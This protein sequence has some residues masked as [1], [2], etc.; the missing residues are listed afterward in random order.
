[1]NSDIR[2]QMS[3]Y[4]NTKVKRLYRELGADGPLSLLFLWLYV[5]ENRPHGELRGMDIEDIA[6]A[7][8]WPG[9]AEKFVDCINKLKFLDKK[10]KLFVVHDWE[11][12][13]PWAFGAPERK[14]KAAKAAK[15]KWGGED[16]CKVNRTNRSERLTAAREKG[17]HTK[18]EWEEMVAFFDNT[19]VRCEGASQLIGVVKDHITPI[20]QGGSD[21]LDN[22][23][24]LCA[25][26]NSSKGPEAI[27]FRTNFAIKLGKRMPAKWVQTSAET[28]APSPSPSP[29]PIPKETTA[30]R[31]KTELAFEGVFEEKATDLRRIFPQHDFEVLKGACLA[32]YRASPPPVDPYPVIYKWFQ[33]EYEKH[34]PKG[35]QHGKHERPTHKRED[36]T[37]STTEEFLSHG[38]GAV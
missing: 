27:D 35:Y 11:S 17:R 34:H 26:C 38:K 33:R 2:L 13:N 12:N 5:A 31:T 18:A 24:P 21:G 1:M 37:D 36:F 6:I 22:I 7:A 19:C 28:S 16:L 25:K 4:S 20:Y 29:S 32:H 10:G 8:Q 23:Q 3:F 15:V 30:T 14:M 9:E